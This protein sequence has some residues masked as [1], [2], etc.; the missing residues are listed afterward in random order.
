M[1]LFIIVALLILTLDSKALAMN[2]LLGGKKIK[3]DRILVEKSSRRL[4]LLFEDKIIKTY[5]V[6]LGMQPLGAKLKRGDNKTPE[7]KYYIAGRKLKSQFHRSLRISYPNNE[8]LAKAKELGID[9]GSDI[10]IHGVQKNH[11]VLD[12]LYKLR[13]WTR[14]CIAVKN[15]EIEEIWSA[16]SDGTPIEI[17]P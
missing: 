4:I 6:S 7:G 16:V 13:D 3:A 11:K 17:L 9:P 8:D 5:K 1:R 12:R 14:G 15:H 2:S 10:M